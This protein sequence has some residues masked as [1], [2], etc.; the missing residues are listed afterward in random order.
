MARPDHLPWVER[1]IRDAEAA[2]E[3]DD[4]VGTGKPIDDLD[5]HYEPAWWA[6]RF[7]ERQGRNDAAADVAAR[8]RRELPHVLA[9]RDEGTVRKRL[10]AYHDEIVSIN[11]GLAS[12]DRLEPLDVEQMLTDRARRHS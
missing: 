7:I 5:R 11:H 3:F 6:R 10:E 12:N 8:L 2:G 4:L 1:V 9:D